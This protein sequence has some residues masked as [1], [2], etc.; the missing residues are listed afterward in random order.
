MLDLIDTE[1]VIQILVSSNTIN[2]YFN[3]VHADRPCGSGA[4]NVSYHQNK[5][6]SIFAYKLYAKL[7]DR[8]L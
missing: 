3:Q 4:I 6:A 2:E 8:L 1:I 5:E 7:E